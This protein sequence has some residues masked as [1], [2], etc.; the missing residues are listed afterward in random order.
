MNCLFQ[1]VERIQSRKVRSI[2]APVRRELNER[3]TV[4]HS[5]PTSKDA[6]TKPTH[7]RFKRRVLMA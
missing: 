5:G 4:Y 2:P 7:R 3:T 1:R 6:W